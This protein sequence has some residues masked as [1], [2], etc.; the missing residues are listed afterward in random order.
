[1]VEAIQEGG[2][3]GRQEAFEVGEPP[4]GGWPRQYTRAEV[5]GC[6]RPWK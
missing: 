2:G 4:E 3:R 1:M 5:E 6:M